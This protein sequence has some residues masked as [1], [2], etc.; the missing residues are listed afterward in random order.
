MGEGWVIGYGFKQTTAKRKERQYGQVSYQQHVI[1]L[2]ARQLDVWETTSFV[3]KSN[4]PQL[5]YG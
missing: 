1:C 5:T 4:D 2:I 3:D